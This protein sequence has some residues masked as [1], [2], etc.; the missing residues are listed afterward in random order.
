MSG[1][2]KQ[3]NDQ[4]E[5]MPFDYSIP[6][7]A[8]EKDLLDRL[9]LVGSNAKKIA[10]DGAAKIQSELEEKVGELNRLKE[11]WTSSYSE[12]K[13]KYDAAETRAKQYKVQLTQI[14]LLNEEIAG[15]Q[16]NLDLLQSERNQLEIVPEEETEQRTVWFK[17]HK[18]RGDMME[19]A[20]SSLSRLSQG[21]IRA[22]IVRGGDSLESLAMLKERTQGA[23]VRIEKLEAIKEHIVKN[24]NPAEEWSKILEEF[25]KLAELENSHTDSIDI[26]LYPK[27][28]GLGFTAQGL[29]A[30][31]RKITP[32]DWLDI[33]LIS[34]KDLPKFQYHIN[35]NKY[36]PFETASPG[37]Q[38]TALLTILLNQQN[39]GPLIIDQPE[40]DLDNAII[41]EVVK[42]IWSAKE[43]RQMI[44]ASHNANLVVNGDAELVLCCNYISS[45]NRSSGHIEC[46]GSI[47][48]TIVCNSVKAVMEGGK[49][50]FE[51]RKAKY[52]F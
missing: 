1:I 27:L 30:I 43:H 20:C 6:V 42:T 17:L 32:K 41:S 5:R 11:R 52:G 9:M 16:Q 14:K 28:R 24:G 47:D 15:I 33:L 31:T 18:E 50:A 22:S 39:V 48:N 7:D 51:L 13:S 35:D 10:I 38:A 8:I 21:A 4:I 2:I 37:Q 46:S 49:Q 12:H 26:T 44:F 34:L 23:R 36:I 19:A 29:L 45:D 40:D 25:K 3:M